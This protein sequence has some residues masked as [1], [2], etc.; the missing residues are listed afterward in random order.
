MLILGAGCQC[1]DWIDVE[2]PYAHL[3]ILAEL[4][5]RVELIEEES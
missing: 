1:H 2:G 5:W 3:A 4:Q